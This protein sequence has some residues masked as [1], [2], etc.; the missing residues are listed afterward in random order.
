MVATM[1]GTRPTVTSAPLTQPANNPVPSPIATRPEVPTPC[2][3]A[4]PIATEDSAMMAATEMSISPA[5]INSASGNATIA[6]SV[7][8]KV[9]SESVST[10]RK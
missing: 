3:D 10:L 6:R 7:K 8:L 9:A 2:A 4:S 5:M 1:E